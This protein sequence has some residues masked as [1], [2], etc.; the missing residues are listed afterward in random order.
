MS[1]KVFLVDVGTRPAIVAMVFMTVGMTGILMLIADAVFGGTTTVVV[2]VL[3][4]LPAEDGHPV[5][6]VERRILSRGRFGSWRYR[7]ATWITP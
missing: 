3:A 6:A 4:G 7:W 1:P 2:W 5:A